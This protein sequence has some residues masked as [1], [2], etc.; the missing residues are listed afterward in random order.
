[1]SLIRNP[2]AAIDLSSKRF[3]SARTPEILPACPVPVRVRISSPMVL[4]QETAETNSIITGSGFTAWRARFD[5]GQKARRSNHRAGAGDRLAG[6]AMGPRLECVSL[7]AA[8]AGNSSVVVDEVLSVQ[9]V[10]QESQRDR[11]ERLLRI[12][13]QR[14]LAR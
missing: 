10:K 1:V 7:M 5:T 4:R 3:T 14:N 9:V 8:K 13:A 2:S 6:R 11:R 12:Q